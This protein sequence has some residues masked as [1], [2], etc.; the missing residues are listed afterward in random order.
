MQKLKGAVT[1]TQAS[2]QLSREV[3]RGDLWSPACGN[4]SLHIV[5]IVF[6]AGL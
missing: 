5:I 2:D 4:W 6:A 3:C 1:E